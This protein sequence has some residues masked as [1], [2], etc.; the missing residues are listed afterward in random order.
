MP[1]P[2]PDPGSIAL[3]TGSSSGIGAAIARGLAERGHGV[4]L[5]ARRG[6]RLESLAGELSSS[7]GVRAEV[8]PADLSDAGER[9]RLAAEVDGL[10]VAV[11]VLV[12]NA[13]FGIYE[14]FGSSDRG[15]ELEQVRL[16]VEAVVDLGARYLPGMLDRRRG[17]ILNL[18]S[19]GG[20]QPLPG[21]ANYA[22]SKAFVLFHSEAVHEEVREHGV[23]VT[24]VCPGPVRTEFQETSRPLF[25]SR[26]PKA[27][28]V[29][30][31]TVAEEGLR[32]LEQGKRTVVP[33]GP[34]VRAAFAPNRMAPPALALP[35]ARLVMSRELARGRHDA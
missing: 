35:V 18:A 26:V 11:E 32:A 19:T 16:L 14:P 33:G 28:W 9:D 1:L 24:A 10:G 30:P 8:L 22:A 12:N 7:H 34:A 4:G 2:A 29:T 27:L 5:I 21:N 17:A 23:T 31:E 15:R 3:I 6:E 25:A 20:F 13:G